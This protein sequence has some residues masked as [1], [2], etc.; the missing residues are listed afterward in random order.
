MALALLARWFYAHGPAPVTQNRGGQAGVRV[1]FR[2]HPWACFFL[3]LLGFSQCKGGAGGNESAMNLLVRDGLG[4]EVRLRG[5]AHRVVSLSPAMSE[6]LCAVGCCQAL[7][8]RDK[9]S[10]YPPEVQQRPAI[11]GF[12]PSPEAILAVHPDLVLLH[13]PPPALRLA[14]DQ[15]GVPWLGFA[16]TTLQQALGALKVVGQACGQPMR[17]EAIAAHLAAR[18]QEIAERVRAEPQPTVFLE[19]DA[20]GGTRPYTVSRRAFGHDL[21]TLAGATNV[22]AQAGAAWFQVSVE[23]LLAAD[24][25]WILLADA[26]VPEQPQS[27]ATL[28]NRAGFSA[29]AAV[30]AR[31]VAPLTTDWVS[32][33]GPRMVLGQEQMARIL[34]PIALA[35]LPSMTEE[36]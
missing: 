32:R 34:H 10:D 13:F 29:L 36:P 16:P 28:Q 5:P 23:A 35:G 7:I 21:L 19:V 26:D 6:S 9:W 24:P 27:I 15:S 18:S 31:R 17:A 4:R 14:L 33:P 25:T 3:V 12:S 30:R 20:G 11:A 1:A 22:F 2:R 8:L